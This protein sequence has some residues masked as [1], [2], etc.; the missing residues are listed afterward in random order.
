MSVSRAELQTLG[1]R[2]L[3]ERAQRVGVPAQ[4]IE[5]ARDSADP[6]GQLVELIVAEVDQLNAM[7]MRDLRARAAQAGVSA[8]A[9]DEARDGAEPKVSA[10]TTISSSSGF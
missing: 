3:R 2:G 6:K 9:I 8:H 7:G 5:D 4:A 1:A 10:A